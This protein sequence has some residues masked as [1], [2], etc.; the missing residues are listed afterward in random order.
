M[1]Q[2]KQGRRMKKMVDM[3]KWRA[4]TLQERL[5]WLDREIAWVEK[6]K[7]LGITRTEHA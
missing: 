5:D 7:R 6:K 3:N 2:L 4:M 1:R